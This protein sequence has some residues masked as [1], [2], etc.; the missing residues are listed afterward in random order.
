MRWQTTVALAAILLVLGTFYY[1][2][3]VRLAPEREKTE[4]RKGRIFSAEPA[5]VTELKVER[6]G[7]TVT[8]KR[9]G[10]GWQMVAPVKARADRG[11]VEDMLTTLVTAKSDREVA[12]N[13]APAELADFGLDKPAATLTLVLKDGKQLGLTLGG[14][15]P[16][17]TWVYAREADK[18][19]VLTVGDTV[20]RDA[21][22]PVA[23]FRDKSI[24]A[25]DRKDVTSLEVQTRDDT[26]VFESADGKWR[27]AK[28][29][30]LA[31]DADVVRDF[32]DKLEGAKVKEFV[33]ESPASRAAWGLDRPVRVSL[34][35]GKDQNRS[36]RT[37][38]LGRV[39][40]DKK[41]LYAMREGESSV[42]L[43]PEEVWNAVPRTVAMA[44]DKTVIDVDRDKAARIEIESGKGTV[45]VAKEGDT[46]RIVA[47][48]PLPADQ[49][50]VG[51]VLFKLKELRAQAFLSED[52]S[53][54]PR[55]LGK[56]DVR[57]SVTEAGAKEPK[58]VLLEPSPER[59]GGKPSAY[60]AVAG[61][62]PVVLVDAQAVADLSKSVTDLRDRTLVP[63][64]EPKDVKRVRFKSGDTSVV[65]DRV[66]DAEWKAVEPKRGSAKSAKVDDVLYI[67]RGLRWREI[68]DPAGKEPAKYGLDT[69]SVEVTLYRADGTEIATVKFGKRETARAWVRTTSSPAVYEVDPKQ[70]GEPPKIPDDIV[71]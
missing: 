24:L 40:G 25:F 5:D 56:P 21:T 34:H 45:V 66:G 8:V 49:V 53:A 15:S 9:E 38:L 59:R 14:K 57:V 4:A 69:P 16:T 41:G 48:E 42:F 62:G 17:G 67:L 7:E 28:P 6:P 60:A 54:I 46:W 37:V 61:H 36:T 23:D 1:V 2:Y 12:A 50:E 71:G 31:A 68:A 65:V 35:T 51:G 55:F 19:A 63:G 30:A 32:L 43:V 33:A 27:I 70:L 29:V 18:P 52:A 39:D 10:A 20:L 3:E 58:T 22:R 13:P 26:I 47:P 11:T 44:R 64:L